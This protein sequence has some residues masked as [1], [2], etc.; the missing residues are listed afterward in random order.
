MTP[1]DD[2]PIGH[3]VPPP[4]PHAWGQIPML[5]ELTPRTPEELAYAESITPNEPEAIR[6]AIITG[7][8]S[9]YDPEIPVNIHDLGLIYG[10]DISD[11][12]HVH[13][14]MTLTSPMC[15]T[16]QG[17]RDQVEQTAREAPHV[18]EVTVE[19]VWDPPWSMDSMTEE[20]RLNLGF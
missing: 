4:D 20:A 15:P 17:L 18:K 3:A 9:I 14:R 10:I 1:T 11:E 16:A 6:D 8:R 7:I 13:V 5:A 19:L 12:R 2:A